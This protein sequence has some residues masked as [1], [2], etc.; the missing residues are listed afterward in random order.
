[1]KYTFCVLLLLH[2]KD[3]DAFWIQKNTQEELLALE[4][5]IEALEKENKLLRALGQFSQEEM[6]VVLNSSKDAV[7]L[8]DLAR[9]NVK[10]INRLAQALHEGMDSITMDGCNGVVSSKRLDEEHVAYSIIKTDIKNAKDS[11]IL[12]MHQASIAAALK[13][14]QRTYAEILEDLKIMKKESQYI[15]TQSREGLHLA[16]KSVEAMEKLNIHSNENLNNSRSLSQRSEEISNVVNLIEDIA[17]QTNLLALNAAIEAARAGEHGRGFAVVADEVR[18]LAERT[19][20][21]TKEI[22]LV[23]QTMQQEASQTESN[24]QDMGKLVEDS[25]GNID[26]LMQTISS[27]ERN[28]SRSVFEV[29]Y[30][31]DKIFASLAKIDHVTYKNNLYALLFGEPNEFKEVSHHECRLGQWYEKGIGKE[32]F[33]KTS[34]YSKL[35]RPHSIV[36]EQANRLAKECGSSKTIC[37]KTQIEEMVTKIEEA[38]KEVFN[39]LDKMVEEKSNDIMLEAKKQLFDKKE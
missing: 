14:S 5:K 35:N 11:K 16:T 26:S 15:S 32:E 28:A 2:V 21:A 7:L 6:V 30:I 18:K 36:H 10:D 4:K 23:V 34:S 3:V 9:E 29:E 20:Q 27:F 39:L 22:S 13:E 19:Q 12:S 31:S 25:K 8:N 37:S 24:T 38:S 17:D 1:L 33:S